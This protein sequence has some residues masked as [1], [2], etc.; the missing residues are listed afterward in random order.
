MSSRKQILYAL[1]VMVFWGSLFPMVKLGFSAYNVSTTGDIMLFAGVRFVICGA[2]ISLIAFIKDRQSYIPAKKEI[3]PILMSGV[4]AIILHYCFTYAALTMTDSSKTAI[5]KQIGALFYVCFSF[6]FFKD[7]KFTVRKFISAMLGFAG[8]IAINSNISGIS[9]NIGDAFIIVASFCTVFS[10]VISKNVY[11][12]VKPVTCVGISQLFGGIFLVF[13][14][15][16]LGGSMTFK[17]DATALILLYICVASSLGYCIWNVIL[18]KG[19]LSKMFIIKFAEPLFA[20]VFSAL[21]LGENIFKIQYLAAFVLIAAG[22]Y[23]SNKN[24]A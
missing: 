19:E 1:L 3:V 8:I 23:I 7:D 18:K 13:V 20:C 12:T 17:L 4:F 14:G 2:A 5:L 16:M 15:V 21:I 9:F 11:K 22:I 24:N 10:S 6:L